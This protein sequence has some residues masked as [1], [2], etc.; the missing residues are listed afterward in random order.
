[1]G[2]KGV[3]EEGARGMRMRR[4]GRRKEGR[5]KR[6]EMEDRRGKRK[7]KERIGGRGKREDMD[8]RGR[9]RKDRRREMRR[10]GGQ[11][12]IQDNF[13]FGIVCMHFHDSYRIRP[14]LFSL[15]YLFLSLR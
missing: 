13:L 10:E 8:D 14:L 12:N 7:G 1:M 6:E 2:R 4:K 3:N 9:E 5:G 15:L 11:T